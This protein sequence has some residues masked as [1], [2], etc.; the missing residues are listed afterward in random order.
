MAYQA[1]NED[2]FLNGNSQFNNF[3]DGI[4]NKYREY[5]TGSQKAR[6]QI[7][8]HFNATEDM[9]NVYGG[10]ITGFRGYLYSLGQTLGVEKGNGYPPTSFDQQIAEFHP[11]N[12]RR[13]SDWAQRR[14]DQVY[15]ATYNA[16]SVL[17]D[18]QRAW[19]LQSW[20]RHEDAFKQI[21]GDE[22]T[23]RFNDEFG[24]DLPIRGEQAQQTV[25]TSSEHLTRRSRAED[26]AAR[27]GDL[28]QEPSIDP[29]LGFGR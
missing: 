8:A 4:V 15:D 6:D 18:N 17:G 29:S 11:A 28:L 9:P 23:R 12:E 25:G 19:V 13:G 16:Y 1:Y 26:A 7:D 20:K 2:R 22:M 10:K 27:F 24:F 21:Q 14:Q 3:F 5:V